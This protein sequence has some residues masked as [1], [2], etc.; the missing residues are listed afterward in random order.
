MDT[1]ARPDTA[2]QTTGRTAKIGRAAAGEYEA[3]VAE[4]FP[5]VVHPS[6]V[7]SGTLRAAHVGMAAAVGAAAYARQQRAIIGRPDSRGML[8]SITVPTVVI[9]GEADQVTPP[10]LAREM[11]DG[12]PGARLVVLPQ[13]GHLSTI[14]Q[15]G[16]VNEELRDW[17]SQG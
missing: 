4:Q 1:S 17:L 12:I 10:D 3:V 11:A 16:R 6:H 8:A 15:P 2:E 13:S 14:E 7:G 5:Q 9:V